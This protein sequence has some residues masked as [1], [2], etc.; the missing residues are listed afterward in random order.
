MADEKTFTQADIDAAIARVTEKFEESVAKLETKNTELVGDLRKARKSSEIKPEDLAAA[1]DRAEK[2]EAKVKELDGTVKTLTK[3]RDTAT[4]A[5]EAES[6]VTHR[7][8]AENGLLKALS[9][10]GVTDPAYLEAAKAMHIGAVKVVADGEGRKALY[11]DKELA[12]AVKE[13]AGSDV[14]KK[15]VSAPNNGGGGAGGGGGNAA[16]K[17]MARSQFNALTPAEQMSFSKE[18]GK[19]VDQAA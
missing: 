8:V 4:K 15:F 18:G 3:E 14:G 16:G 5:L 19:L 2:A 12:E 11:G 1:E 10:A 9:D 13:W 6:S 7:L 17:T